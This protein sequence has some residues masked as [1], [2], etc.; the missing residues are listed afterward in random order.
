MIS[1][2]LTNE[3][4]TVGPPFYNQ[5]TGPQFAALVLLMGVA[6][7]LAWRKSSA[8]QLGRMMLAPF[9]ISLGVIAGLALLARLTNPLALGGLWI[10]V[11]VGLTTLLEFWRGTQARMKV[12][13]ENFFTAL[14]TL[15]A[16]NRRR[17]GGYTIHLGVVIMTVGV[18]GSTFF[19][20]ETQGRLRLGE[21]LTLGRY[22]MTYDELSDSIEEDVQRTY[23]KVT[24]YRDGQL[25]D[26]LYPRRDMYFSGQPMTIPGVRS[27][28]EDDFYV[29]LVDWEP[30][31]SNGATF[32]VYLNPL[33]NWVWAGGLVFI[34]GTL[35]AAW[36][37]AAEERRRVM[38][39]RPVAA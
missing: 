9:V 21:Q 15:A 24:V 2:L 25:V 14:V 18:I 19:Q 10:T 33:V 32:K 1:E 4:I 29:I 37:D 28:V 5:V 38:L 39:A 17:Y 6:P 23:A 3:K 35:I 12:N 16:R 31:A 11:F 13:Q 36:P 26:T 27:S 7:L 20:Q 34:L 30:I 22:V 8:R